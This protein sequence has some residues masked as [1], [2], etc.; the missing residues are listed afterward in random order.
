MVRQRDGRKGAPPGGGDGT[1][2][3]HVQRLYGNL[4]ALCETTRLPIYR[5]TSSGTGT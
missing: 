5:P 2:R 3:G 1:T 4:R